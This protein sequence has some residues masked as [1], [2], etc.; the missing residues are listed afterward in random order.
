MINKSQLVLIISLIASFCLI[1]ITFLTFTHPELLVKGEIITKSVGLHIN[2]GFSHVAR[3]KLNWIY[4]KGISRIFPTHGSKHKKCAQNWF[5]LSSLA[6][7]ELTLEEVSVSDDM[8]TRISVNRNT[9]ALRF[10]AKVPGGYVIVTGD[11]MKVSEG[12]NTGLSA[13]ELRLPFS[14]RTFF[15]LSPVPDGHTLF[16]NISSYTLDFPNSAPQTFNSLDKPINSPIVSGRVSIPSI[17]EN[18]RIKRGDW[19]S[20]QSP[21]IRVNRL[22]FKNHRLKVIFETS[23]DNLTIS[24]PFA[25]QQLIPTFLVWLWKN[26]TVYIYFLTVATFFSVVWTLYT[27]LHS[28]LPAHKD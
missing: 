7:R 19:M 2:R 3:F 18:F 10:D 9:L 20:I 21:N 28:N 23:T 22:L 12:C 5:K 15:T 13:N 27:F 8:Y 17:K 14:E 25:S 11:N 26:K 6:R 4:G 16:S 24:N 1:V